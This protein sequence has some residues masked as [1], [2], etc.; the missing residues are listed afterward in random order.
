MTN[1][2]PMP[3]RRPMQPKTYQVCG[4]EKAMNIIKSKC[5]NVCIRE[6]HGEGLNK[7]IIL[8]EALRELEV[9]ISYGRRSP[10]NVKEQKLQGYG[11]T[12]LLD[13]EEHVLI[14]IAH[15][16]EIHTTNRSTTSAGNLSAHGDDNPGLDILE[17]E[18]NE[19]IDGEHAYNIDADGYQVNPF[20]K[21]GSP[22]KFNTEFHTHP[23]LGVFFSGPDKASGAARAASDPICIFVCDPIRKK[24]K[25]AIG[26]NLMEA[27]VI[28]LARDATSKED[29]TED[30]RLIPPT[31]EIVRL[32]S[33]CL[34]TRGYAGNVRL[35]S[36]IN[37]KASLKIKLVIPK[38][39][40]KE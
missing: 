28:A 17:Y 25:A 30:K 40:R 1:Y 18:R 21:H 26:K 13:D 10:R 4:F 11:P 33:Q 29:L 16:I 35:R 19:Y 14:V 34:R 24:M 6:R 36:H 12:F 23:D 39:G 20:V 9:L 22:S 32:T 15:F 8:P 2:T 27:E 31:D 37:G 5:G 38:D 3:T 7:V